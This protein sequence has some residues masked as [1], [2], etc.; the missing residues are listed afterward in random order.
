MEIKVNI[1]GNIESNLFLRNLWSILGEDIH[2]AWQ[3]MP[4]KDAEKNRIYFGFFGCGLLSEVY[5]IS[6]KYKSKGSIYSI[7]FETPGESEVVER[8]KELIE[9]SVKLALKFY[10][11]IKE[12]RCTFRFRTIGLSL[13]NYSEEMFEIESFKRNTEISQDMRLSAYVNGFDEI[14]VESISKKKRI[15][16]VDFLSTIVESS[17][18]HG[19]IDNDESE[20]ADFNNYSD[21]NW[22][23]EAPLAHGKL[24]M[25]SNVKEFLN[26]YF[27]EE[28][29]EEMSIYLS[30][31]R[32]YHTALK[33]YSF[34]FLGE[35]I[36]N[37]DFI[38]YDASPHE[39]ANTLFMSSLE[40]LSKIM[41]EE[42]GVC[43]DCGQKIY[44]I[45]RRVIDL[46]EKYSDGYLPKRII[47]I[48][49]KDR[50]KYVHTG[51]TYSDMSYTGASIPTLTQTGDV[52]AQI[53][54]VNL[55]SL[56]ESIGFIFRAVLGEMVIFKE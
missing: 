27:K 15:Q 50:S 14:D 41:G 34:I 42:E 6:I 22:I 2:R 29:S 49:Y 47:D 16:I 24:L 32:L 36:N 35:R 28:I 3:L 48:Y 26:S 52:N 21:S 45:R 5:M 10:E 37:L 51:F 7:I 13:N 39:I 43:I 56:K 23:G 20:K 46:C 9:R 17:L 25:N 40:V 33:Y 31:S 55:I 30:A 12:Y 4:K 19:K 11:N 54:L 38:Q 44:S 18:Y 1:V 53:P 8:D